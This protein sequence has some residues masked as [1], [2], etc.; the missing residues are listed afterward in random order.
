MLRV[1]RVLEIT[2]EIQKKDGNGTYVVLGRTGAGKTTLVLHCD[3]W[4]GAQQENIAMN[5]EEVPKALLAAGFEGVFHFDEAVDGLNSK[6]SLSKFNKQMEKVFSIIRGK[7]LIS[8]IV[9]PSFKLLAPLFREDL[10]HGLFYVYARGRVA[11]Y[12]IKEISKINN[13]MASHNNKFGGGKPLWRDTFPK[14]KGYLLKEYL[15]RKGKRMDEAIKDMEEINAKPKEKLV[16]KKQRIQELLKQG[17]KT[18]DIAR[19]LKCAVSWV[20]SIKN[21][22]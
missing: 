19:E 6:D 17:Y 3:E 22:L 16:T 8:F 12:D 2:K 20:A 4:L 11:F 13:Y 9:L 5:K 18:S 14:Y 7:R 15:I 1:Q 10:I 21:E